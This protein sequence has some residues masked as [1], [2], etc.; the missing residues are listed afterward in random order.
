MSAIFTAPAILT[1]I[2]S[3]KDGGLSIGFT[4]SIELTAEEKLTAFQFHNQLGVLLFKENEF[5]EEEIPQ[6]DAEDESKS[7]S[8]RLRAVLFVLWKARGE[9]QD[10]NV[11][12][13]QEIER[14][15]DKIKKLLALEG[16]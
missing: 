15:I 4:T 3:M 11:F 6:G 2:S 14:Q 12:Y 13:R 9:K 5:K 16:V 7:P 10:F 8:Q 1:R